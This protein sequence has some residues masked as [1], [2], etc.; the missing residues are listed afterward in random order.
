M[1]IETVLK[2]TDATGV[3]YRRTV[4]DDSGT[5]VSDERVKRDPTLRFAPPP[6]LTLDRLYR[7]HRHRC[8]LPA[9]RLR[10]GRADG[11]GSGSLPNP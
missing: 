5:I 4:R 8:R 6:T 9:P 7:H 11:R 1:N 10:R 3:Y 2:E